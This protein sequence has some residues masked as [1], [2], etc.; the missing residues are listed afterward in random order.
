MIVKS[1]AKQVLKCAQGFELLEEQDLA[2]WQSGRNNGPSWNG[3]SDLYD[4]KKISCDYM[5]W[6]SAVDLR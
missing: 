6:C 3:G 4:S 2:V 1:L 5:S